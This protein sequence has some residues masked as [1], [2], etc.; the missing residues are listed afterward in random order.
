MKPCRHDAFLLVS[1]VCPLQVPEDQFYCTALQS[2]VAMDTSHLTFHDLSPF[3][4]CIS[5]AS[6][7][8][9]LAS[10]LAKQL[11]SGN[12]SPPNI[13]LS[14]YSNQHAL[15]ECAPDVDKV[16]AL[17][18]ALCLLQE[19]KCEEDTIDKEELQYQLCEARVRLLLAE[20]GLGQEWQRAGDASVITSLYTELPLQENKPGE[21]HCCD[22]TIYL[23]SGLL[24]SSSCTGAPGCSKCSRPA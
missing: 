11:P 14:P 4:T 12:S 24:S 6:T 19:E 21:V 3:L 16:A 15:T 5:D 18:V 8:L 13:L 7:R 22:C 9:S 2:L 23:I 10:Q 17:E 1:E 20:A